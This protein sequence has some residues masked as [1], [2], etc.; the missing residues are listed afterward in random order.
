VARE[1]EPKQPSHAQVLLYFYFALSTVYYNLWTPSPFPILPSHGATV[2][3]SRVRH[4]ISFAEH[5]EHL[6]FFVDHVEH[7]IPSLWQKSCPAPTSNQDGPPSHEAP[8]P[9]TASTLPSDDFNDDDHKLDAKIMKRFAPFKQL[10]EE[11]ELPLLLLHAVPT[12]LLH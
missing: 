12:L 6:I 4:F 3:L 1:A 2:T 7:F 8:F 5:F 10:N 11:P 9:E